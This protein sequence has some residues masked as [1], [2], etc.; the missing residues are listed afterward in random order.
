MLKV[1]ADQHHTQYQAVFGV[2]NKDAGQS[3]KMNE[4]RKL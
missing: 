4:K 2:R 1:R 3:E